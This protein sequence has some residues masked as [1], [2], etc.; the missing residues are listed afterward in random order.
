M[1]QAEPEAADQVLQW[2]T[3]LQG[4]VDEYGGQL[5]LADF[6]QFQASLQEIADVL[7]EH[8]DEVR[9]CQTNLIE[10]VSR[11]PAVGEW[12]VGADPA[13]RD[14][15]GVNEPL[16]VEPSVTE[17]DA[18]TELDAVTAS[19]AEPVRPAAVADAPMTRA[20]PAVPVTP[21]PA[22]PAPAPA[23]APAPAGVV[24]PAVPVGEEARQPAATTRRA[25]R[26][27]ARNA[28]KVPSAE[29]AA[30]AR[31][32]TPDVVMQAGK[33]GVTAI[34]ALV[35]IGTAVALV[36]RSFGL[37]GN[38]A[39]IN[40]AKDLLS[41][42]LGLVGTVV[43]YYFGRV[44]A[45]ARATTATARADQATADKEKVKARARGLAD[46]L[47]GI[48]APTSMAMLTGADIDPSRV[49]NQAKLQS[50][51]DSLRDLSSS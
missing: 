11:Y 1:S 3:L 47:D 21:A 27:Q 4:H 23:Y 28:K 49:S 20:R 30:G 33:E 37:I 38:S 13:Y 5:G 35:I 19:E 43:G 39:H 17:S 34:I 41:I 36:A 6:D 42:M 40:Q 50:V 9:Q 8:P 2:I 29:A 26:Q 7:R 18:V 22:A 31:S 46:D 24:S 51:R 32:W 10:L 14:V 25:R 16:A 45:D 12:L 44:P 15:P 48:M